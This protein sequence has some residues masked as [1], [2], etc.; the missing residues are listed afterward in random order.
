MSKQVQ[1]S[2]SSKSLR[3]RMVILMRR[4]MAALGVFARLGTPSRSSAES[5]RREADAAG[6]EHVMP[7]PV[8]QA[9]AHKVAPN[10]QEGALVTINQWWRDHYNEI[11]EHGYQLRP[12][13]HPNWEPSW[14]KSG[15]DFYTVEDGQATIVR[16]AVM[17]FLFFSAYVSD[18]CGQQWTRSACEITFKL[19]SKKSFLKRDLT[20]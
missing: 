16:V 14:L 8:S 20:N 6:P 9:P 4:A 5:P 15:K 1:G 3:S 2:P 10:N 18:S 19:C 17:A 12:R 7:S 11:A 13:Y